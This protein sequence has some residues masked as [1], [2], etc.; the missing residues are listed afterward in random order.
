MVVRVR[1]YARDK[2]LESWKGQTGPA[3]DVGIDWCVVP[4]A[5]GMTGRP[6]PTGSQ[7]GGRIA[8]WIRYRN[9]RDRRRRRLLNNPL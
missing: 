8:D 9:W 4:H 1:G 7:A 6:V 5:C 3:Q 2:S